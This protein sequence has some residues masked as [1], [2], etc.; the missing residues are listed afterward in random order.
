LTFVR[1]KNALCFFSEDESNYVNIQYFLLKKDLTSGTG[2]SDDELD[3]ED[4]L[5]TVEE[6]E[7]TSLPI[8]VK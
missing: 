6:D 4:D 5:E 2:Q 1:G 3:V 7:P 8:S